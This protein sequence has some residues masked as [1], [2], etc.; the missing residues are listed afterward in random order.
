MTV[1]VCKV[2]KPDFGASSDC[3][4]HLQQVRLH[5]LESP[6][7]YGHAVHPNIDNKS[8]QTSGSIGIDKEVTFVQVKCDHL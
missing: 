2:L 8:R 3:F 5:S 7:A 6:L 4:G 1:I